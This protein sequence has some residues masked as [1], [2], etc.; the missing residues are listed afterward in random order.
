MSLASLPPNNTRSTPLGLDPSFPTT[1]AP[2]PSRVI[3]YF[4]E[5]LSRGGELPD[6]R[7]TSMAAP[8]DSASPRPNRTGSPPPRVFR[9]GSSPPRVNRT[10]SSPDP[11]CSRPVSSNA[12][13]SAAVP[14]VV[15]AYFDE[16]LSRELG[17]EWR[18]VALRKRA[19]RPP[20]LQR[21]AQHQLREMRDH[22]HA[23]V[24]PLRATMSGGSSP[25]IAIAAKGRG[26][27]MTVLPK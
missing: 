24:G 6:S 17:K 7:H 8:D 1:S 22:D 10:G 11:P 27:A 5:Q 16:E 26:A 18:Y 9:T 19:R 12:S 14:S 4:E 2:V 3:A 20:N 21:N 25:L 13:S 15:I 23:G